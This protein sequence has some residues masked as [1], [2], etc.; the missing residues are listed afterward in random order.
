[1]KMMKSLCLAVCTLLVVVVLCEEEPQKGGA[2]QHPDS[3]QSPGLKESLYG[4][5][6][7]L[8][9]QQQDNMKKYGN[10]Y[11][12][13]SRAASSVPKERW[14]NAVIP[15]T[16]DCSV[17][18]MESAVA[19]VKQ[20]MKVWESKTCIR[21]VERTNEKAY[22]EFFRGQG[23]WGHV[24][25]HGYKTQISIGDNCDFQHVME[26]EI[27]HSVGFWHEQSRPDRDSYI[28]VIWENVLD[29]LEDAFAKRKWGTEVV[30]YGVPYDFA[31]IM[32]YPFTAFSKNGKPTIRNIVD[33]QGK[34]PY[35]VLS[36]GDAQQTNAMYKCSSIMR[37][38]AI[39]SFSSFRPAPG[40]QK[41]SNQCIDRSQRC[42][43]FKRNGLC[44]QH[45]DNMLYWCTKT[46]DLCSSDSCIDKNGNCPMWAQDGHCQSAP[47]YM[48]PNCPHSCN[49][50]GGSTPPPTQPPAPTTTQAPPL[51]PTQTQPTPPL[52]TGT[53]APSLAVGLRCAD[54]STRCPGWASAGECIKSGWTFRNCLI[55]CK[56]KCDTQPP[57]PA[58]ACAAPLGLGWD[59]KLP[60][61]AF[62]ASSEM[63]PG[64]GWVASAS[65][66]RLYYEDN[67]DQKRIGGWCASSRNPQW[68]KV[69]VG[70]VKKITGIATQGRDV[71]YEHVKNYELEFSTDSVSWERY[72]ENGTSKVFTGNCDHFTPVLNRF[73]PVKARYVKVLPHDNPQAWMCMR[74]EL[75]GCDS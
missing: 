36:D 56:A 58:G 6:I 46:C 37:K 57:Q 7:K 33:M 8:T 66:A 53:Q 39:D 19:S 10:P 27:G 70:Q 32:H 51:P 50:C 59:Y 45:A 30:D 71:F 73:N 62:S 55:S 18:N 43:E 64:G 65:N 75:Y 72:K 68:L 42:D 26:H 9:K 40:V 4:G 23:C 35:V 3:H 31:S 44:S 38:R 15:F 21:F 54:K 22:L 60:D 13:Q 14:P 63:T 48:L 74:L 34:T 28:S 2:E 67:H 20:A 52:P 25:H 16:F 49:V 11:G 24:G 17:A 1:M 41:R 29:G 61:S 12:P 47:G 5:D 69:D